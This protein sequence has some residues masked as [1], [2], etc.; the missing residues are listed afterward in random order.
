[1]LY[2]LHRI[3]KK[4]YELLHSLH[5]IDD[6][7]VMTVS[8]SKEDDIFNDLLKD[9]P[10]AQQRKIKNNIR[11][12]MKRLQ[13][14]KTVHSNNIENYLKG[15][16]SLKHDEISKALKSPNTKQTIDF[17]ERK[18]FD[19]PKETKQEAV[20][21]LGPIGALKLFLTGI[22]SSQNLAFSI[23]Q[24]AALVC[25]VACLI[26]VFTV[27]PFKAMEQ[28]LYGMVTTGDFLENAQGNWLTGFAEAVTFNGKSLFL[29]TERSL[30]LPDAF[31]EITGEFD[32]LNITVKSNLNLTFELPLSSKSLLIRLQEYSE[33]E[34]DIRYEMDLAEA[35]DTATKTMERQ[36]EYAL[37]DTVAD[38]GLLVIDPTSGVKLGLKT[39]LRA[40]KS[41]GSNVVNRL[42]SNKVNILIDATK[43]AAKYGIAKAKKTI[44]YQERMNEGIVLMIDSIVS[45][46]IL[47][48]LLKAAAYLA[49]LKE[50]RVLSLTWT[51][52]EKANRYYRIANVFVYSLI[53]TFV[54]TGLNEG[55][56]IL[57]KMTGLTMLSNLQ[58]GQVTAL[59]II[60]SINGYNGLNSM[61]EDSTT[62]GF[63][64][65]RTIATNAK[66][67]VKTLQERPLPRVKGPK[68]N[69]RELE[70]RKRQLI[71]QIINYNP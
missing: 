26:Q 6:D 43:G 21:K 17:I 29:E 3:L 27:S 40:V 15:M 36:A 20:Q 48:A 5:E 7:V 33:L 35:R 66:A 68:L 24:F 16:E 41:W 37:I 23:P 45:S 59:L 13:Q 65:I 51:A 42:L 10:L 8:G 70:H 2:Q 46:L 58:I 22:F 55:V 54:D 57:S 52:A 11:N 62:L 12:H 49:E 32:M 53:L 34:R 18:L 39:F 71:N 61:F 63:A 1:M 25:V 50:W 60:N 44:K 30:Y 31:G 64:L 28:R 69:K 4:E 38:V 9:F 47:S 14:V 19:I 67:A 56:D